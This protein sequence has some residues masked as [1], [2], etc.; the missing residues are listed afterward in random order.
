MSN[1]KS[2]YG[3]VIYIIC[4]L[5]TNDLYVGSSVNYEY[6]IY[7]HKRD[8]KR[9]EHHSPILQNSYNKYGDTNFLFDILESVQDKGNLISREQYWMDVLQP[10]FN[11]AKKAGSPLGVKHTI[12]ARQ[13]MS[14]AHKGIK[15]TKEAIV[16]RSLK[17]SGKNHWNYG[18]KVPNNRKELISSKLSKPVSQYDNKGNFIKTWSSAT[19]AA[20]DLKISKIRILACV[21][22]KQESYHNFQWRRSNV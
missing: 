6:R 13:N 9:K 15:L 2:K 4:N 16:K 18:K 19:S 14:N 17:Q 1:S 7:C 11:C 10:R 20:R 8:L 12:Q 3:P 21:N 22:N 5:I